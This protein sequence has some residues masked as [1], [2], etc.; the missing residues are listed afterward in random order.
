MWNIFERR[1]LRSFGWH[2]RKFC[3]LI[4]SN[5][6]PQLILSGPATGKTQ[7]IISA[8]T[9][10]IQDEAVDPSHILILSP[11]EKGSTVI[12][13]RID[14]SLSISKEKPRVTSINLI[15]GM[16][17]R[18]DPTQPI[19]ETLLRNL[20]N[21]TTWTQ[22]QA[23]FLK[24]LDSILPR[25]ALDHSLKPKQIFE[26]LQRLEENKVTNA[27]YD[28]FITLLQDDILKHTNATTPQH[29]R[30]TALKEHRFLAQSFHNYIQLK[31]KLKQTSFTSQLTDVCTLSL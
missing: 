11:W 25:E 15:T 17:L 16:L 1:F 26:Y 4:H 22:Q 14:Q 5:K 7:H 21:Q 27:S 30:M 10:L 20:P 29:G 9:R 2:H 28:A 31:K 13:D 12:R 19:P 8:A 6:K 18:A 3:T 24:H 23:F